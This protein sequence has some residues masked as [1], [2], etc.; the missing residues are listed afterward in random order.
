MRRRHPTG[1]LGEDD[2][3]VRL[4]GHHPAAG[5]LAG[6]VA[7]PQAAAGGGVECGPSPIQRTK[8]AGSVK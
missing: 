1:V 5:D 7:D 2:P 6:P 3:P 4:D 8:R